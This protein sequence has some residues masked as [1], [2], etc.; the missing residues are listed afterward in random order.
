M[1]R[2]AIGGFLKAPATGFY[3]P[4]ICETNPFSVPFNVLLTGF[5]GH[6]AAYE[7]RNYRLKKPTGQSVFFIF[8]RSFKG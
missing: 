6:V 4:L 5:S 8:Q 7:F 3:R 1:A 2:E